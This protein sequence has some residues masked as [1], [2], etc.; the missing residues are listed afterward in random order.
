MGLVHYLFSFNG[1]INRA[2]QWALFLFI[3]IYLAVMTFV[4]SYTI[5][6]TTLGQ[7]SQGKINVAAMASTPQ[8][9]LFVIILSA[10]YL[11]FVYVSLA[12]AAKRLHDR[13]KSV[14]W[15]LLFLV[16]PSALQIPA[17]MNLPMHID[18]LS[19]VM[20]SVRTHTPVPSPPIEPPLLAIARGV[21]GFIFLWAFVELYCLR[22]TVGDNRY[23]PDPLA[24]RR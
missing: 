5:G 16:L 2:K 12:V 23:G 1:R 14:W 7:F 20:D 21:A 11:I 17:I 15:L 8:V 24:G 10:I 22:G 4:L 3:P 19:A 18:Y 6:F 13:N 9:Q